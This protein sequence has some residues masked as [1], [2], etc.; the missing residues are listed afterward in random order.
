MEVK[1]C[2]K[3]KK[4]FQYLSGP[5]LCPNCRE[6]EEKDFQKVKDYLREHPRATITEVS[7]ELE[8]SVEKITRYLKEGRLEIAP[9]SAIILECERCGSPITTGRFCNACSGRL[10]SDL[11]TTSKEL[12]DRSIQTQ[13]SMMKFLK[14]E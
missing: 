2:M 8:I 12:H 13:Q 4:I 7:E 10:E 9:G 1:N 11:K 5:P 14:K 3:C 6:Q